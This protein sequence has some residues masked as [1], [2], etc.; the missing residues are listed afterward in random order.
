MQLTCCRFGNYQPIGPPSCM[1][2]DDGRRL[3]VGCSLRLRTRA[4]RCGLGEDRLQCSV[5]VQL[6]RCSP[7][8]YSPF[9]SP[10][11]V[12]GYVNTFLWQPFARCSGGAAGRA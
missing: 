8:S 10:V 1:C 2:V 5:C 6:L 4:G 12:A 3:G 11:D 7:L 9:Y